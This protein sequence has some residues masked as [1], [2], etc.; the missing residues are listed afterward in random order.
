LKVEQCGSAEELYKGEKPHTTGKPVDEVYSLP[1]KKSR[2]T[3]KER[4]LVID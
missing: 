2:E 1:M 3:G 4:K